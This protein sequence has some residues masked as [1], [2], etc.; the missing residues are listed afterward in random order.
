M[1]ATIL[2]KMVDKETNLFL[3]GVFS[4]TN[5]TKYHSAIA[6]QYF[7]V[8]FGV[9]AQ[10]SPVQQ[11]R[12]GDAIMKLVI[13]KTLAQQGEPTCSCMGAHWLLEAL[14][15]LGRSKPAELSQGANGG[16]TTQASDAALEFLT[17]NGTVER[18]AKVRFKG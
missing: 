1:R 13:N 17:H 12:M 5:T 15:V 9:M 14:Y 8:G 4:P 3:D 6:S 18:I 10:A 2:E 11:A 7:P 16:L